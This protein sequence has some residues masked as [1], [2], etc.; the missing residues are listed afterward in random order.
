[1]IDQKI[2]IITIHDVNPSHSEKI[3]K[4]LDEIN[5]LRIDY[6]LSIVPYYDKKYNLKDFPDFS[7]SISSTLQSDNNNVE[8]SL[9]GL[10]HQA[11][12][13]M[14]DFDTHT[15]EEEKSEIQKGLDILSSANLPRPS[16]FI[17][18]AWHLSRQAIEALKELNFSISESMTELDFI[19]K[20]KKYLLHPVMNWDQQG[21]KVKNKQTLKPNKQLFYE[22][23]FNISGGSSGLFRIAIH[24]PNDPDEAL[25]DQIEMIEYLRQKESYRFVTYSDLL[26]LE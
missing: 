14:D 7:N 26:G 19:Q 11:N 16:I 17:P 12:G 4:T 5:K 15:K 8:L 23:L 18:P 3:V 22:R 21:D 24:P 1:M 10:Y 2:A 13:Q 25:E 6:N 9:H 20:G